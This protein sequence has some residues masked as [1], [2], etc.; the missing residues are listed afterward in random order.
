MATVMNKT[1]CATCEKEKAVMKCGGCLKDFCFN[2]MT[3]HR[4]Q[5]SQQLEK[6]EMTCD[7]LRQTLIEQVSNPQKN[8]LKQ[9][10]DQ[11]ERD[12]IDKIRQA[13]EETRKLLVKH[14]AGYFNE[15]EI[16]LKKLTEQI[17]ESRQENDFFEADLQQWKEKLE[18]LKSELDKPSTIT[19]GHDSTPLV[20]KIFI[21]TS[22]KI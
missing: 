14:M 7:L 2:H 13:A 15:I 21:K 6:I 5:L 1:R 19:I 8:V 11:W 3:D 18:T 22:G 17:R 12:S 4:Q 9:Q 20:T 16:K 10:M